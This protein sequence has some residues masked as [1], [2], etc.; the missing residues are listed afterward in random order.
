MSVNRADVMRT[1]TEI[2]RDVFE[3][4]RFKLKEEMSAA[5]VEGWDSLTHL[6]LISDIEDEYG[7]KFTLTELSE[8]K[9]IGEMIDTIMRHLEK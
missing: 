8:L 9:N 5:D 1:V 3:R 6:A 2:A 7:I 4:P